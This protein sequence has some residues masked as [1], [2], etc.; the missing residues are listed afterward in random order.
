LIECHNFHFS[1]GNKALLEDV[2]WRFS[3]AKITAIV[4]ANGAGK[5]TLMKGFLGFIKP[6][7][8]KVSIHNKK[9]ADWTLNDLAHTRAYMAQSGS[10]RVGISVT[11]YLLLARV[12][13]IESTARCDAYV[14]EVVNILDLHDF[15]NRQINEL[16]GGE[17][18]RVELARAWCQLLNND[19]L[20]GKLLLLDEPSSALDIRQSQ[21]LYGHLSHFT[22]LGGTVVVV[23][24]DIN[25]AA[26]YSH[27]MMLLKSGKCIA[28]G[29]TQTVFTEQN[30]NQC[31]DVS[32]RLLRDEHSEQISFTL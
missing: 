15:A 1:I 29:S 32:G 22:L 23:E 30:I 3:Q 27:D 24:H 31:F 25:T 12:H 10:H 9:L 21:K 6:D 26:K 11:E 4:G 20:E 5:S 2:S 28:A 8:G 14:D 13:H 16:S 17:Y 7:L 18:Q 19:S